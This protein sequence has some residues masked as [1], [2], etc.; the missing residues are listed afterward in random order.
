VAEEN[1]VT[2]LTRG[3]REEDHLDRLVRHRV[4]NVSRGVEGLEHP[5]LVLQEGLGLLP[6]RDEPDLRDPLFEPLV[7]AV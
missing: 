7:L 2:A 4:I 3:Q 5:T 1:A 6:R